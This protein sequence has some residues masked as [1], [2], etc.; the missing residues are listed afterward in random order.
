MG[1]QSLWR[2]SWGRGGAGRG[3]AG[4]GGAGRGGAWRGDFERPPYQALVR[5]L[6]ERMDALP[7]VTQVLGGARV[8]AAVDSIERIVDH[9][10]EASGVPIASHFTGILDLNR[11]YVEV[12]RG[13]LAIF[14][15]ALVLARSPS[16]SGTSRRSRKPAGDCSAFP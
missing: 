2:L 15:P 8:L 12:L 14:V 3:G 7:E 10:I 6:K 5:D 11:A 4:R 9:A 1:V 16:R 13:D